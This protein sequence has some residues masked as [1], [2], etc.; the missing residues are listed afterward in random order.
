[1]EIQ[2]APD[3]WRGPGEI[4]VY[5]KQYRCI[6][7]SNLC[8]LYRIFVYS[9]QYRCSFQKSVLILLDVFFVVGILRRWV[10][11][12]EFG[13]VRNVHQDLVGEMVIRK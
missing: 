12:V 5:S 6:D 13:M 3:G 7:L 8:L 9:K 10:S 1:M 11:P 2:G 4:F